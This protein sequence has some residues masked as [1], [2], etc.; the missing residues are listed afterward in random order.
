MA[1][2]A[3]IHRCPKCA[4]YFNPPREAQS[5]CPH[6]GIFFHKWQAGGAVAAV[7]VLPVDEFAEEETKR[8]DPVVFT[9]R[10]VA[11][12]LV[13]AWGLQLASLDYRVG[14]MGSSFMHNILL[15]IHE[16]GHVF[17][18]PFGEFLTTLGGSLFQVALPFG[19]GVAFLWKQREPFG[20]AIML[21]WTGASFVDL[22]PYVWDA[23]DPQLTLL[24]GR[25]GA[26]GPH[27]WIY[28]LGTIGSIHRAH[29]WG[30]AFHHLGV[31][32]MA[33]GVAWGAWYCWNSWK[34][35]KLS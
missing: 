16:A 26:D 15:P 29:G 10:V 5:E 14:E 25:T 20:A 31:L 35:R 9:G 24:G 6:C 28:L 22:S 8:Y 27:D 30:T 11:L 4:A 34:L 7:E 2:K 17:L 32:M 33:A 18:M 1:G 12:V 19:I 23:L 13:A 3:G 21:W